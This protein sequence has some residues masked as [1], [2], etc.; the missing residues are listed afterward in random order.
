MKLRGQRDHPVLVLE[1]CL[2]I[3]GLSSCR[4]NSPAPLPCMAVTFSSLSFIHLSESHFDTVLMWGPKV[5]RQEGRG[6][7]ERYCSAS[8]SLFCLFPK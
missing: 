4:L 8:V 6:R 1:S 7:M 5:A 3:L 2:R